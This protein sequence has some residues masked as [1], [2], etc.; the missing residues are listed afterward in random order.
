MPPQQQQGDGEVEGYSRVVNGKVV[1][2]N[3]YAKKSTTTTS[4][5]KK[6]RLVP[7]RPRIMATPGSYS[8]GRDIPDQKAIVH[9]EIPAPPPPVDKHG[10]DT[11]PPR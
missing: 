3:A 11:P 1:K 7:G 6:A 8:S 5:A 2:V 9:H 10:L 4:A